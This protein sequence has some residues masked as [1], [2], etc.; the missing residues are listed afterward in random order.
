MVAL[1]SAI[2][3]RD[4]LET[5]RTLKNLGLAELGRAELAELLYEGI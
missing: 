3:G 5:G 4:F 2:T 1:G